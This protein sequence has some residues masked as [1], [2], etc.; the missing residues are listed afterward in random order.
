MVG[1]PTKRTLAA[2]AL[3]LLAAACGDDDDPT[4]PGSDAGIGAMLLMVGDSSLRVNADGSVVGALGALPFGDIPV[5]ASF[6]DEAGQPFAAITPDRYRFEVSV[7]DTVALRWTPGTGFSG[8]LTTRAG[9][10]YTLTFRLRD[11]RDDGTEIFVTTLL[12]VDIGVRDVRMAFGPD[13]LLVDLAATLPS[14]LDGVPVGPVPVQI[15]FLDANGA[16]APLVTAEAFT[17]T[18]TS[19]DANIVAFTPGG[20]FSGTLRG[21][22]PGVASLSV[23]LRSA[24]NNALVFN[25][26]ITVIVGAAGG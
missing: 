1:F 19:S 3:A 13:T 18:V 22:A 2:L 15:A 14:T 4:T 9:G 16:P 24:V 20:P 23:R 26:V 6:L 17:V 21:V 25:H 8:T 10:R 5:A 12:P 7:A 11:T